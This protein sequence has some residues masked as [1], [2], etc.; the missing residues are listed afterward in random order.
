M[1]PHGIFAWELGCC[2]SEWMGGRPVWTV[3]QDK[4]E[5]NF[6]SRGVSQRRSSKWR[7][8]WGGKRALETRWK[9][10]DFWVNM[11]GVEYFR[12]WGVTAYLEIGMYPTESSVISFHFY[13]FLNFIFTIFYFTILYWFCHQVSI[14]SFVA[15]NSLVLL[16]F[17]GKKV[18]L[19]GLGMALCGRKSKYSENFVYFSCKEL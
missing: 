15:Q 4:S 9:A 13:F 19:L 16:S 18:F 17:G 8:R 2:G 3:G 14:P 6:E 10:G 11:D 5:K 1:D 7:A 12:S